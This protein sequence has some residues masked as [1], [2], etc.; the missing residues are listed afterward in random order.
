MKNIQSLEDFT[1]E[2]ILNESNF[3]AFWEGKK[4]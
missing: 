3:Y 2:S 1:N 4:V